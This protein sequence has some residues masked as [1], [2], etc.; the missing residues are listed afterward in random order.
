MPS[1]KRAAPPSRV[2]TP[3]RR[4]SL[5]G[6][7]PL[8]KRPAPAPAPALALALAIAIGRE[9][10]AE[11]R[12]EDARLEQVLRLFTAS[13]RVKRRR[14]HTALAPF[15]RAAGAVRRS[16]SASLASLRC[17]RSSSSRSEATH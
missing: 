6:A 15:D 13:R 4:R 1:A 17:C 7:A 8:Q 3:W 16:G 10:L 5:R 11:E 12:L 9:G 14:P 2:H